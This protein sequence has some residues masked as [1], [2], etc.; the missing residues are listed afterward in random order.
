MITVKLT[1]WRLSGRVLTEL[2]EWLIS[3]IPSSGIINARVVSSA[4]V[5]QLNHHYA[6]RDAATDVLSFSYLEQGE[7]PS[8]MGEGDPQRDLHSQLSTLNSQPPELGDVV[9]SSQHV[10]DQSSQA[11]TTPDDECMLLLVHGCLHVLGIDHDTRSSQ[12]RMDGMQRRIVE[13]L[14]YTYRDFVWQDV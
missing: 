14:G 10:Y 4:T 7:G 11:G 5:R 1:G 3:Y 12:R 2:G 9:L 8:V 6:G 13:Q